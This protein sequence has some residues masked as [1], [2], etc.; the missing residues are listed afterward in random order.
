VTIRR[1]E[2]FGSDATFEGTSQIQRLIAA[3]AVSGIHSP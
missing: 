1:N 3:R 2:V